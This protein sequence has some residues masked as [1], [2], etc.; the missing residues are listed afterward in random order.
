MGAD[1]SLASLMIRIRPQLGK[2]GIINIG[3]KN[4][5]TVTPI[6]EQT[7]MVVIF[8]RMVNRAVNVGDD[9]VNHV[10]LFSGER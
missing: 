10:N 8:R 6:Q 4:M 7:A 9:G 3:D 2:I 1:Q 5:A